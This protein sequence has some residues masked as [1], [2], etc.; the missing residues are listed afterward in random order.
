VALRNTGYAR[1][2]AES[3]GRLVAEP[4]LEDDDARGETLRAEAG[5]YLA[6]HGRSQFNIPGGDFRARY[7]CS[8]IGVSDGSPI[9][10]DR[11]DTYVPTA[12]PG[13]R[14]PHLWLDD[15]QSLF[16]TFGFDWTLL[17]IGRRPPSGERL[18]QAASRA[19]MELRV[20]PI[21][22]GRLRALYEA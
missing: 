1:A 18:R 2:F 19:G 4:G 7:D 5:A 8:P 13:G 21:A 17:R 20:V 3:L 22:S 9:P 6:A 12:S 16:D 11:A 10:L 14:A 15:G